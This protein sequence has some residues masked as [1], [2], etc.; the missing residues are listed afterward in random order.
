MSIMERQA[1]FDR[2]RCSGPHQVEAPK[3]VLS[4]CPYSPQARRH[5]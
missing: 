3:T 5:R 2:H 4:A 1:S